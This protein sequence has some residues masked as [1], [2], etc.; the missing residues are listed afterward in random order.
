MTCVVG[1]VQL[2]ELRRATQLAM[3]SSIS[4]RS[5]FCER[6]SVWLRPSPRSVK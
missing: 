3:P 2:G 4:R 1:L 6:G 5:E